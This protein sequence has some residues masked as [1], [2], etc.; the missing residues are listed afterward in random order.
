MWGPTLAVEA[1]ARSTSE[2]TETQPLPLY[3]YCTM[4]PQLPAFTL[5]FPIG[6][7]DEI[8]VLCQIAAIYIRDVVPVN[9][10]VAMAA[11]RR[12]DSAANAITSKSTHTTCFSVVVF[13]E[14]CSYVRHTALTL[15]YL[16]AC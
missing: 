15:Q 7:K 4:I 11:I 14:R 6:R 10:A 5:F 9:S 16:F 8:R 3:V 12:G 13:H 2:A 1:Q